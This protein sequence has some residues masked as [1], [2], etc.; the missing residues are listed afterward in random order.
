MLHEPWLREVTHISCPEGWLQRERELKGPEEHF[1]LQ[2]YNFC[3]LNR[4]LLENAVHF[5]PDIC[6]VL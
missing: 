3:S 5:G 2:L 4:N 6:N 1:G